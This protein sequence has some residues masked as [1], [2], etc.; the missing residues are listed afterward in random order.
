MKTQS[1]NQF[2]K[3]LNNHLYEDEPSLIGNRVHKPARSFTTIIAG[4]LYKQSSSG[5]LQVYHCTLEIGGT[6]TRI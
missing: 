5:E 2:N 6:L 4:K 1:N 3:D